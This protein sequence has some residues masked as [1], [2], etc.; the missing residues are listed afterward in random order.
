M[1]LKC[2][3]WS[4]APLQ[5]LGH[6]PPMI[7]PPR[8]SVERTPWLVP[9]WLFYS[10]SAYVA[11]SK[12]CAPCVWCVTTP[13]TQATNSFMANHFVAQIRL[14][15]LFDSIMTR[16]TRTSVLICILNSH[17]HTVPCNTLQYMVPEYFVLQFRITSLSNL[18]FCY[19]YCLFNYF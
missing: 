5:F 3:P 12:S 8:F 2:R 6:G 4:A 17:L 1:S 19:F 7:S 10:R 15:L 16:I 13:V 9:R 18:I 11:S 14:F